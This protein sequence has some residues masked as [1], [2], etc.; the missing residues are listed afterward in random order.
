MEEINAIR[1]AIVSFTCDVG[2]FIWGVPM[3]VLLVGTH[4]F[5]TVRTGFIQ[6]KLGTAIK[7]SFANDKGAKG[8]VSQF[9]AL[10]VALAATIGTGNIVGVGTAIAMGGPGAV[11]WCWIVGVFGIATK[12]SE[13]LLAV[14]YRTKT[15]DGRVIGGAMVVLDKVM[16]KR[17]LAILF[18]V[19]TILASFG[20]GNMCQANSVAQLASEHLGVPTHYT[21]FILAL[22]VGIV[23]LG[24]V[25]WVSKVCQILVPFM[26][27]FY[28]IGCIWLLGLNHEYILPAVRLIV[29]DAFTLSSMAGGLAGGGIMLAMRYGIARGLFSNESGMGSAPLV[30]AQAKT[31][32]AVRQALISSTGTFWDTVIVCAITGIVLVSSVLAYPDIDFHDG[33][34]LTSMAFGKIHPSGSVVLTIAL[35]TFVIS[36]ILGWSCYGERVLE[37]WLGVKAIRYYRVVWT[38][39]VFFGAVMKL[40]FVWSLSD[41]SNAFMAI[42]NLIMVLAL[43]GVIATETRKYLWSGNLD[44]KDD[45]MEV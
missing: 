26:A 13:T 8:E 33:S 10:A 11:F 45:E 17:W 5:L 41:V 43:S 25:K 28:V 1:E 12:Y 32:N 34:H 42:P 23:I 36:T 40:E 9:G 31:K 24:G 21:G 27:I 4:L 16:H 20:I 6:R 18:C 35:F 44:A 30:A 2:T 7:I 38:L 37:Y 29:K 19:F 14:K 3:I 22:I 39:L 15:K